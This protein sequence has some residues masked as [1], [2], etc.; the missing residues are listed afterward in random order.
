MLAALASAL[1]DLRDRRLRARLRA[2]A[3][4]TAG[5][6]VA[7]LAGLIAALD[8]AGPFDGIAPAGWIP[9]WIV[10][11]GAVAV[12]VA[13]YAGLVWFTFVIVV[14][15]VAAFHLDGVVGRVEAIDYPELPPARG[16]S[17]TRD[18][19]STA[20][21]GCTLLSLNLLALPLYAVG[22]FVPPVTLAA[23]YLIN[24]Y[25][26]GREYAEIV[27]LRRLSPGDAALWRRANRARLWLAGAL[28]AFGMTLPVVNLAGPALAAA[29]M[30]HLCHR[31]GI[32]S[33]GGAD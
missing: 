15:T 31:R 13:A 23:F 11:A 12:A 28:I 33:P 22:M 27:L 24:G 21:F 16:T 3:M 1:G 2:I 17:V 4:W 29:F 6:Y 26:F 5:V 10:G 18:I 32:G 30:T 9:D 20:R 25:L 19:V 8:A 14:Q 7:A